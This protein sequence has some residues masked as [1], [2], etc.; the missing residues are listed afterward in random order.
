MAGLNKAQVIGNLGA[1][2][3]Y[4]LL[5]DESKVATFS[6][7]STETYK[8]KNGDKKEQTDWHNIVVWGG[9]ADVVKDYMK[10]G[11][12]AYVEGKMRTRS[13]EKDGV[14]RY[15]TEI[16]ATNLIMLSGKSSNTD[17]ERADSISQQQ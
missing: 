15:V 10:K 11:S 14:T 5:E 7:A 4:R 12:K 6:M 16:V 2:P 9:L 1:E 3:E 13:Y 8:D 17:S